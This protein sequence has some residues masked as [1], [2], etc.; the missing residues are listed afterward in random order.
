MPATR[1][2][3]AIYTLTSARI[4]RYICVGIMLLGIIL[5]IAVYLQNRNLFIDEANVARNIYERSFSGLTQ[6]LS[7][8]QYAPPVFLWLV[9]ASAICFG[10]GEYALKL[11]PLLSG[12][13]SLWLLYSI[14]V[15]M[16]VKRAAWYPLLLFATGSIYLR[17]A[18]ELKQYSSDVMVT[19]VLVWLALV[20][21][22]STSRPARFIAIWICAGSLA[23][24]LSMPSVFILTG[25]GIYYLS[26]L[27]RL[28][29]FERW[30]LLMVPASL[31]LLQ[32]GAY[33]ITILAPQAASPYLQHFHKDA[34]IYLWPQTVSE[35]TYDGNALLRVLGV[36]G[37]HWT[38]SIIF[39]LLCMMVAM[40]VT[41]YRRDARMLLL[42]VPVIL[43]FVAAGLHRF[44]LQPRV[45]LFVMPLLLIW[46]ALGLERLLVLRYAA[47]VILPVAVICILNYQHAEYLWRPLRVT[48]VTD[49][50]PYMQQ[51]KKAG[52]QIYVD[53]SAASAYIYY[54]QIHPD[55]TRWRDISGGICLPYVPDMDAISATMP[56]RA[57]VLVS[58][59]DAGM[60]ATTVDGMNHHMVQEDVYQGRSVSRVLLLRKR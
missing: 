15:Q 11:F 9:K 16:D 20:T 7:Y 46:I 24:W 47:L 1:I 17:Y 38:L 54:T 59:Q 31:W 14:L 40:L 29:R 58:Y 45:I 3:Q 37:G 8:D 35:W 36:T 13:V 6:P 43:L 52:A 51:Q 39:H 32:F 18:T 42:L 34:F 27:Y 28:R 23:V 25:V 50:F 49:C 10:Y 2:R 26:T 4:M 33:Y 56:A 41:S 60:I 53:G 44:S 21:D 55:R 12:L 5:R 57:I 48:D 22:V 19:L 30:W